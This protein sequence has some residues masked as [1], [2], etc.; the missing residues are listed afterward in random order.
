MTTTK[1]FT[2]IELLVVISIIAILAAML[3]PALNKAREKSR[4][5]SCISNNKQI[6]LAGISYGNDFSSDFPVDI[7]FTGCKTCGVNHRTVGQN[8]SCGKYVTPG[9]KLW[10]CPSGPIDDSDGD[11]ITDVQWFTYGAYRYDGKKCIYK[12]S[13]ITVGSATGYDYRI[14][15]TKKLAR[16]TTVIFTIDSLLGSTM[17][18]S[19]QVTMNGTG[20]YPS[21]RHSGKLLANYADGHSSPVDPE[22]FFK[23][24]A[25][26]KN[27]YYGNQISGNSWNYYVNDGAQMAKNF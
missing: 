17:K 26:N 18:Q 5:A 22:E 20:P 23:M 14:L 21:A 10:Y 1:I 13:V 12:P 19:Y 3:L 4:T 8:L 2:L 25:E 7:R 27:D 15:H 16:P 6:A 9:G 11:G 24:I